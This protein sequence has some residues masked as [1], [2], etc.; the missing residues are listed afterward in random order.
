MYVLCASTC[1]VITIAVPTS[2]RLPSRSTSA[3]SMTC[4]APSDYNYAPQAMQPANFCHLCAIRERDLVP[5]L[6]RKR[7]QNSWFY[8]LAGGEVADK[9]PHPQRLIAFAER[10]LVQSHSMRRR[11]ARPK[12]SGMI[13]VPRT[14]WKTYSEGTSQAVN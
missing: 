6:V 13:D 7:S 1:A 10:R 12:L 2:K 9:C 3:K 14:G 8:G 4:H 11:T 5:M